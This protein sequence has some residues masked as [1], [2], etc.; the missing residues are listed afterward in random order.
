MQ[1]IENILSQDTTQRSHFFKQIGIGS[2]NKR[3]KYNFGETYGLS[4]KSEVKKYTTMSVFLPEIY[5]NT[6]EE[7]DKS[8]DK[9]IDS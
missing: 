6:K 7:G 4:I 5:I 8:N 1:T 3:I 9:T 2:V